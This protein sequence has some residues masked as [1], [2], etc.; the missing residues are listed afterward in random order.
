MICSNHWKPYRLS[1]FPSCWEFQLFC[2]CT[3]WQQTPLWSYKAI[4]AENAQGSRTTLSS[5]SWNTPA[6]STVM[7]G[8]NNAHSSKNL[9]KVWLWQ[10]EFEQRATCVLT[11]CR[12]FFHMLI[13]LSSSNQISTWEKKPKTNELLISYLG[14]YLYPCCTDPK[15]GK[16]L[17]KWENYN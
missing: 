3:L 14:N 10:V 12:F 5:Q 4:K 9:E 2:V 7:I 13:A 11:V 17:L 1:E 16:F 6:T 15:D 8:T